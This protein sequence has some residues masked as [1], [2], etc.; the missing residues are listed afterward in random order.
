M[1]HAIGF[2]TC[3]CGESAVV[4]VPSDWED[5]DIAASPFGECQNGHKIPE[6]DMHKTF[7]PIKEMLNGLG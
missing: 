4:Y 3:E 7:V 6:Q 1:M 5:G 2:C